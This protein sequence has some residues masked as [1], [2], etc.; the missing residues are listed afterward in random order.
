MC[1]IM[2][3]KWLVSINQSPC[4]AN[5]N[6]LA[7]PCS[8]TLYWGHSRVTT[9]IAKNMTRHRRIPGILALFLLSLSVVRPCQAQPDSNMRQALRFAEAQ[10]RRTVAEI[11][12]P[13][14]FPR[15]TRADGTW[16]TTDASGWTSGFFAGC[17]WLMYDFSR[18]PFYAQAARRW[19]ESLSDMQYFAGSHDVGFMVFTSFGNGFRLTSAPHDIDV[20]LQSATTLTK[21]YSPTVGCIKSWD[22]RKWEYPVIIDNMMNLELL[23]WAADHGGTQAMRDIVISHAT[24]TLQNHFRPDGSTYHVVDFDTSTGAVRSRG[25]HQGAGDESVWARGQAWAIYGFTM[26]YRYTRDKRYLEAARKA[27]DWYLDNLPDGMI[28]YWDFLAPSIPD[29]PHDASAAAITASALCEL[30]GFCN[31][32]DVRARYHDAARDIL[33]VLC[34]RPFL[35]TES[36]SHG[37]L[38]HCVGNKPGASEIDVSLIYADYYFIEGLLRYLRH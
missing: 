9:S 30:A 13:D 32:Q 11:D 37:I 19:T 8:E 31:D 26:A 14:R 38:N 16:Q 28:P 33:L 27:A 24:K 29:E 2:V 22:I 12:R 17:L 5:D 4:R 35:A 3:P 20:L 10:L 21:R 25:T 34:R 6:L 7:S 1:G 15:S 23:F 36:L 18:D